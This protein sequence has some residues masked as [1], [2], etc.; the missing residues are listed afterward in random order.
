[1][2]PQRFVLGGVTKQARAFGKWCVVLRNRPPTWSTAD[3][4]PAAL[5][6]VSLVGAVAL[7]NDLFDKSWQWRTS[8][9]LNSTTQKPWPP[10][11]VGQSDSIDYYTARTELFNHWWRI[12]TLSCLPALTAI[13]KHWY[14]I[15]TARKSF[16]QLGGRALADEVGL[17]K[18]SSMILS[19]GLAE[20][21]SNSILPQPPLS[22]WQQ[23]LKNST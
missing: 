3:I 23:E 11:K 17:G 22:Q 5:G 2:N 1:M 14:Q 9:P 8:T 12:T 4:V 20:A 7:A 13:D 6:K 18:P 21:W 19:E 10:S 16:R 15:E